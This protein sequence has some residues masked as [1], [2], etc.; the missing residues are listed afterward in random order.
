MQQQLPVFNIIKSYYVYILVS[1]VNPNSTYVGKTNDLKR[2]L[3]QHNGE[4]AGGAKRTKKYRPWR[5]Y[6]YI[7]GFDTE[8]E[9]LQ[10]EWRMHHPSGIYGKNGKSLDRRLRG[11]GIS[12]REKTLN[13]VINLEK[14][15][16]LKL[17]IHYQL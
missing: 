10:F 8:T 15:K 12:G 13:N 4:I 11:K 1:E 5:I 16:H 9:A 6:C 14:W 17:I 7:S 2:R 3:R